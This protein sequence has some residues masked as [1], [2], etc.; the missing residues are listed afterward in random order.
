MAGMCYFYP[1]WENR[2]FSFC[3]EHHF[4][5][6]HHA[7][8]VTNHHSCLFT[9]IVR[10]H[11]TPVDGH[12]KLFQQG[13]QR[14]QET[15]SLKYS[16]PLPGALT[17]LRWRGSM[18]CYFHVYI[19]FASIATTDWNTAKVN[20]EA[21]EASI[22]ALGDSVDP[23]LVKL[24]TY[25]SGMFFQGT[26]DLGQALRL[27][28]GQE[29][30]LPELGS[31]IRSAEEQVRRDLAVLAAINSLWILQCDPQR[32]IERN[33]ALLERLDPY[34]SSNPNQEIQAAFNLTRVTVDTN[35]AASQ[36]KTKTYLR[37]ALA[38]AQ[39]SKNKHLICI[40]LNVMCDK[41]FGGIVGE[42]ADKSARAA[43]VQS[44]KSGNMLWMSVADGLLARSF[45]TEGNTAEAQRAMTEAIRLA[46][47]ALPHGLEGLGPN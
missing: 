31:P 39:V 17:K 9:G 11:A 16:G 7:T 4:H 2:T 42:Q 18:V 19:V 40:T 6:N 47:A 45:E 20:L 41:F 29:F 5:H 10:L 35:T 37:A 21:L 32:D 15:K 36:P 43:S 1:F 38:A 14:A 24:F 44:K 33:T 46:D 30:A 26:G 13:L 8:T 25:L 28:G 23:L 34:C 27:Y 12:A 3:G 22:Q